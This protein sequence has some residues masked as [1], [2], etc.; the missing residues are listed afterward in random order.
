MYAI[1]SRY[2]DPEL[3][4]IVTSTKGPFADRRAAEVYNSE[5]FPSPEYNL[6]VPL[7]APYAKL[8]TEF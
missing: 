8:A 6:V 1:V 7:Y 2:N 3:G 5:S 4:L